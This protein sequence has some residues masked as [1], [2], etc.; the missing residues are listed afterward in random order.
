MMSLWSRPGQLN[1]SVSF[2]KAGFLRR[3]IEEQSKCP[4][5]RQSTSLF[6]LTVSVSRIR[7]LALRWDLWGKRQL[8]RCGTDLEN[9]G[10]RPY[11]TIADGNFELVRLLIGR[12]KRL[13]GIV[14]YLGGIAALLQAF[15]DGKFVWRGNVVAK[16]I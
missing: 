1:Q 8:R 4:V 13:T 14:Q 11:H 10:M 15:I 3:W 6:E 16:E 7:N 12:N 9:A 2:T 5:C